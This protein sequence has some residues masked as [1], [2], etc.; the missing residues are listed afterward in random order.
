MEW[1]IHYDHAR[2]MWSW[3]RLAGNGE[4]VKQSSRLFSFFSD[5]VDDA[6]KNGC[7]G[8]PKFAVPTCRKSGEV[9]PLD[10]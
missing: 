6:H 3:C 1:Y 5:A 4:L 8:T 7:K 9:Q 2:R 10:R